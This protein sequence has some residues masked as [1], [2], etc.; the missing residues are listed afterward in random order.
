MFSPCIKL[1]YDV[2]NEKIYV[3]AAGAEYEGTLKA[4]DDCMNI[5]IETASGIVF[6]PGATIK[7]F[8]VNPEHTH[9]PYL[10]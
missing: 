4:C 2:L 9:A 8:S 10:L 7:Y 1:L 5:K 6:I 3:K